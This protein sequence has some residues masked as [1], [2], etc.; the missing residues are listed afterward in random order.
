MISGNLFQVQQ[1][2]GPILLLKE[3]CNFLRDNTNINDTQ[4]SV[5]KVVNRISISS[6]TA[7]VPRAVDLNNENYSEMVKTQSTNKTKQD[8]RPSH[9]RNFHRQKMSINKQR[10]GNRNKPIIGTRQ[11][12]NLNT[13]RKLGYLHVYR[14]GTDVTCEEM[15]KILMKPPLTSNLH[16][17]TE[18]TD[19]TTS[20]KL[21]LPID[22]CMDAYNPNIWPAGAAVRRFT[23]PKNHSQNIFLDAAEIHPEEN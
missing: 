1:A 11:N 8:I 18:K 19:T 14:C 16:A 15:L 23:F 9:A 13:V 3:K 10:S 21:S 6:N 12:T 2:S 22:R 20:L 7:D 5:E 4:P 17:N